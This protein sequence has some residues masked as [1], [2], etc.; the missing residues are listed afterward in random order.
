MRTLLRFL[1]S[2]VGLLTASYLVPGIT[3]ERF[4]E[5]LAVAVILGALNATVGTL[6]KFVAFIPVALSFGCF[7]LVINGLVFWLAGSLSAKLGLGFR[8]SGFWAGFFGAL[9]SS[10]I[11]S[12]LEMVLL[13]R[14]RPDP[15]SPRN[16][17]II[18]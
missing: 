4:L 7:S 13:G 16:L 8:V 18:N 12:L 2:A 1:F 9:V 10:L 15:P 3:H 6:L 11:A 17:K 14:Q 5:L